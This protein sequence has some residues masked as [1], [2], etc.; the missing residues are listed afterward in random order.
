MKYMGLPNTPEGADD[1]LYF[2]QWS[3]P[4]LGTILMTM[5]VAT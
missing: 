3:D 5:L 1:S 4:D 2:T